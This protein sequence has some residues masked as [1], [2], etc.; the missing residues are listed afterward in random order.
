[1]PPPNGRLGFQ[2]ADRAELID[3]MVH[4]LDATLD[5]HSRRDLT[6][7]SAEQ[8]AAEQYDG[9]FQTYDC[10]RDW[11]RIGR[12]P[13]GVP[14]GFVI[15]ARNSYNSIIAYIGVLPE[16]RGRGYIDDLL[17]EGTRILAATDAPRIRTATDVGNVPMARAF[18]RAGY[19]TFE[20]QI[21][22]TWD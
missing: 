17:A 3:V 21:S 7:Q 5:A 22:M 6:R 9:E 18:A 4:V 19:D 20:R 10:P 8:V 12:R 11:W 2:P 13:D 14:V 16:H 1:V 15:P